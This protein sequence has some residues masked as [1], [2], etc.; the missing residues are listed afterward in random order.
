MFLFNVKHIIGEYN[1]A[2]T[3]AAFKLWITEVIHFYLKCEENNSN[4]TSDQ[5]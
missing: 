5:L 1:M 2:S 3:S 4:F